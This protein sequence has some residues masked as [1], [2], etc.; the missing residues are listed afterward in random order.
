[1]PALA[2]VGAG[3][4]HDLQLGEAL[5]SRFGERQKGANERNLRVD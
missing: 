2:D 3:E 5:Q 1:M 4:G